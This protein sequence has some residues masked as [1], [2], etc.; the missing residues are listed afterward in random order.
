VPVSSQTVPPAGAILL[1]ILHLFQKALLNAIK[2]GVTNNWLTILKWWKFVILCTGSILFD[3]MCKGK[4]CD[5]DVGGCVGRFV[6]MCIDRLT[7]ISK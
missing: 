1:R 3:D 4:C 6:G 2:N 5:R 7:D